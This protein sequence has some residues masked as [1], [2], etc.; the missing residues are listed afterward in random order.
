MKRRNNAS[1]STS[2]PIKKL[3]TSVAN[4]VSRKS[5]SRRIVDSGMYC[6]QSRQKKNQTNFGQI[7]MRTAPTSRQHHHLLLPHRVKHRPPPILARQSLTSCLTTRHPMAR[8][9]RLQKKN[10]ENKSVSIP[11]ERSQYPYLPSPCS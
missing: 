7:T 6:I 1:S 3:K 8:T 2:N 9:R 10:S 5:K 4:A 11:L